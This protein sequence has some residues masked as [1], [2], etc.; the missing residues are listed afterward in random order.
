MLHLK[1]WNI[2]V[3]EQDD[4]EH[5][6]LARVVVDIQQQINND[7]IDDVQ[8]HTQL[9]V[10][11]E[12]DEI[13]DEIITQTEHRIVFWQLVIDVYDTIV[14]DDDEVDDLVANVVIHHIL[15]L[16]L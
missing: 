6:I 13:C 7:E 3:D 2:D 8:K 4:I 9:V 15:V 1:V 16:V 11:F 5:V 10:V 14:D 12:L